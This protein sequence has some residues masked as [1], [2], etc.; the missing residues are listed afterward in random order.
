VW[1]PQRQAQ[2]EQVRQLTRKYGA[3][4][5]AVLAALPFPLFDF[6]GIV[7]GVL[8]MRVIRFL[9]AVAIGKSIKYIILIMLG[10]SSLQWLQRV[11]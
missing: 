11:L 6:A 3:L 9:L 4:I 5:L 10:A 8:R 2:F 1:P 7:A